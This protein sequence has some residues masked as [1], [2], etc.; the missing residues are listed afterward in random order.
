MRKAAEQLAAAF[1]FVA[2]VGLLCG[3][4]PAAVGVGDKPEME[5]T[6]LDGQKVSLKA[7]SGK[8]VMVDF[9]ATWCPPCMA[10]AEHMVQL[11]EKYGP[12]GLVILGISLD[13]DMG[14]LKQVIKEKKFVWPNYMDVGGKFAGP[15]G[16]DGIPHSV[17]ISP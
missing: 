15:W 7:L 9:W 4:S 8:I 5:F 1:L 2:A 16:V 6:A 13:R 14:A 3:H 11:N 10:Q 12:K 17:I